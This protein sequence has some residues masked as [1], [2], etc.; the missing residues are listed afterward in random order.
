MEYQKVKSAAKKVTTKSTDLSKLILDTMKTISDIVG[1]TL[2]PGGNPVLIE[3]Y[4]H[5]LGSSLTK[6][7]VTVFRSLGFEDSS[8]HC[9]METARDSAVR[10]ASEAGDGPQP[11][12]SKILTP[13]GFIE[14]RDA[15]VG[16]D[17]CGTDGTIQKIIGVYPKG[18]KEIVEVELEQGQMVECCED[19]LWKVTTNYGVTKIVTT[20]E[21]ME[22]FKTTQYFIPKTTIEFKE[23]NELLPNPYEYGLLIGTGKCTEIPNEYLYNSLQNRMSLLKGIINSGG[24]VNENGLFEFSTENEQLAFDFDELCKSLGKDIYVLVFGTIFDYTSWCFTEQKRHEYGSK[25]YDIKRTGRF[26]EM[27]CIKVSNPD[28][29][30]ITNGFVVTHN[31]TTATILSEAVVRLTLGFC[32]NNPKFSPQ[33]VVRRLENV[34]KSIIEPT[35]KQLSI[36][37]DSTTKEG[38]DTLSSVAKVSANGDTELASAVMKCFEL[39]GDEG[40]VTITEISGPSRYEVERIE[41]FSVPIGYEESCAKFYPKFINDPA[42]QRTVMDNPVFI[43]YH[44]NITEIQTVLNLL[45]K[46]GQEWQKHLESPEETEWGDKHNVVLVAIGF[47]D[48][49]LGNLAINFASPDTINVFP[50]AVPKSPIHNGQ[51]HFLEDLSAVTGATLFDPLNNP[52]DMGELE[53]LGPGIKEFHASRYRSMLIGHADEELL[54]ERVNDLK[55]LSSNPESELDQKLIEERI[56]KLTGGIAKL[57]VIGASNGELKEKR[58]RAED[59]VCAVRGAIKHGCLPGGGWTLI[60][61]CSLLPKDDI[62]VNQVLIPALMEPVKRLLLNCGIDDI[63]GIQILNPIFEGVLA[64]KQ[65]VYDA[66]EKK[67]VDAIKDGILDSTPAVLEA[68]RNSLSCGSNL[69]TLGGIIVFGRDNEL[70]KKEALATSDFLRNANVN[71]ADERA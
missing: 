59:A 56:G 65:I 36:H 40:N 15:K 63:E 46:V 31:T 12:W 64:G 53:D 23:N 6:D 8:A 24:H 26:T 44:G 16:M 62:V 20:K 67:H 18:R 60:K 49:V 51:L 58:D 42:T 33:K 68:I 7:G 25:V 71:P 47:S 37:I 11:L 61:L 3:R 48:T 27:Q 14:M 66:M 55:I 39:V 5:G 22:D 2:G 45:S 70:E 43:L 17:I 1:C 13:T 57:K 38:Q 9:I 19:H 29:L 52:L 69:G 21:M 28:S 4:E 34:F 32:L 50:L 41:G 35:I 30:Y 10:T 54:L